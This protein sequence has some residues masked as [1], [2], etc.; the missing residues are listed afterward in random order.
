MCFSA[1]KS[2][3]EDKDAQKK[4]K[5]ID[6]LL[7]QERKKI[8]E[9]I[10]LLLLGPGE[11]GKSTFFK[12]MKIIQKDGG[13]SKDEKEQ[14]RFIIIGNCITQMKVLVNASMKFG[15]ELLPESR[16][17]AERITSLP[18]QTDAYRPRE[19]LSDCELLWKDKAIKDAYTRRDVDFQLNDSVQYFFDRL[20]IFKEDAWIPDEQDILR[21]RVRT[22]GIDEAFFNFDDMY[23]RMVDVGGQRT[24]R[25]KWIHCFEGVTSVLF[26]S[27]LS[28]Y[29]QK[30]REDPTQ[31]RMHESI[32]LFGEICNSNWFR[33][34]SI[35]LFLNKID[36]FKEKIEKKD[37]TCC[38][39]DYQGGCNYS[40]ATA[41]IQQRFN[42]KNL[43][44]T[45]ALYTHFTCAVDTSNIL[46]VFKA[47]KETII[48]SI[49]DN[50][51]FF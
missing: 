19:N 43:Q 20:H 22:T 2:T 13:Y 47:V 21:A 12:Q 4:S 10:K 8:N 9:E 35:M 3:P 37:L 51:G 28:E 14:Y 23:F 41:F 15:Y 11:S 38:F 6:A 29:D 7:T 49:V 32:L 30:L 44:P 40:N 16:G 48:K 42:E 36:L 50:I 27:S 1:A 26:C 25:R 46:F 17:P 5:E 31:N 39:P 33:N 45:R 34:S 18:T 24:E